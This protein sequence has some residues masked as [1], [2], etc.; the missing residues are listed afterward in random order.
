[1]TRPSKYSGLMTARQFSEAAKRTKASALKTSRARRVLVDGETAR[2]VADA[3]RVTIHVVYSAIREVS[4]GHKV[5]IG[6]WTSI[7][8]PM[9]G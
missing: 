3:D 8:S 4:A 9:G 5:K 6:H 7:S 2:E 1:M